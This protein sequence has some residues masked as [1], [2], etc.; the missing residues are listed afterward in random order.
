MAEDKLFVQFW[1]FFVLV[2]VN[3]YNEMIN[4]F[5]GLAS[6]GLSRWGLSTSIDSWRLRIR[7]RGECPRLRHR[8]DGT[9]WRTV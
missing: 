4:A 5:E 8:G 3:P 2:V 6:A 9:R 1:T 7:H